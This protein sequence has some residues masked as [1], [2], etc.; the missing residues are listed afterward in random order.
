MQKIQLCVSYDIAFNDLK[1][2]PKPSRSIE[3][4]LQWR[5]GSSQIRQ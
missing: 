1:N 3:F 4:S 5:L 2:G